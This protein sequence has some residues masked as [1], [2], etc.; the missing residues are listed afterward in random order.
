MP[1]VA[2][3]KRQAA[4]HLRAPSS[5]LAK[6][7]LRRSSGVTLRTGV[8]A[9]RAPVD[10]ARAWTSVS[11]SRA[12]GSEAGGEQRGGEVVVDGAPG[13]GRRRPRARP[14]AAD[15]EH[16][17]GHERADRAQLVGVNDAVHAHGGDLAAR[18]G[19]DQALLE[20]VADHAL[21][22]V[23]MGDHDV[24][25][26]GQ[27]GDRRHGVGHAAPQGAGVGDDPRPRSAL[28]PS[29]TTTD[30][31]R[32]ARGGGRLGGARWWQRCRRSASGRRGLRAWP[33]GVRG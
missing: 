10:A 32:G 1:P 27:V 12:S 31:R 16:A 6:G 19:V 15:D 22:P 17:R 11:I 20:Q 3:T 18:Q 25:I 29:A 33:A 28:P 4:L 5:R 26:G 23:A 8:G 30:R 21:Q 13:G 9:G 2:S 24:V 14:A 7:T